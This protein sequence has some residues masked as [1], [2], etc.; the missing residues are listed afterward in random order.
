MTE[1]TA[2]RSEDTTGLL[3]DWRLG[4]NR[5]LCSVMPRIYGELKRLAAS[6]MQRERLDHTLQLTALVHEA[7]LRLASQEGGDWRSR[8]HFFAIAATMMRRV[9]VDYFRRREVAKRGG[10][11]SPV[12]L[13]EA[14]EI[15]DLAVRP[16]HLLLELD[17]ALRALHTV[18][19]EQARLVELRF[20]GGLTGDEIA[21]VLGVT[22]R[23]VK[24]RWRTARL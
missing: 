19:P 8:A 9:L 13:D 5:A 1:V 24:R 21:E 11:Q 14:A 4:D 3:N 18:D 7:F 23:T 15:L 2:S 16:A 12:P 17:Q 6:Q 20:F 22:S 10:G